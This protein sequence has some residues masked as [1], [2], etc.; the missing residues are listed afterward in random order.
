[1]SDFLITRID[2]NGVGIADTGVRVARCL[3]GE[4]VALT[5][6]NGG[7]AKSRII[8]P[9]TDRVAPPCRHFKRCGG[10]AMQHAADRFVADWKIDIVR[11]GLANQGLETAFRPIITS[12]PQ[13][14]RRATLHGRRTKSGALIGFHARASNTLVEIPDC[15]LLHPDLLAAL[16]ALAALVQLAGSRKHEVAFDVTLSRAGVDVDLRGAK[17]ADMA[18]LAELAKLAERFDLA[19]LSLKGEPVATRRTPYLRFGNARVNFPPGGFLQATA[20]GEAALTAAVV[21]AVAGARR[22][23]DLFAGCGT[24]ALSLASHA[25]VRAIEGDAA[26]CQALDAAWRGCAGLK[27]VRTETRDL[28]RRP[29]WAD[30]FSGVDAVVIDPPRAGAEAQMRQLALAAVAK[31]AMVS[32]NPVSFARDAAILCHAG[33]RLDWVQVVDQFRWSS[34][35]ELVARFSRDPHVN[36]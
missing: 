1:M 15:Q 6:E 34:H 14:R 30:E 31:V 3:P 8:K 35:I 24:F 26:L 4:V 25:E 16:P 32:C 5:T 9:S 18:M 2:S 11:R 12:S 22:V 36:A 23:V 20:E 17:S 10:C 28:F 29:L 13:S 21:D 19:R 7:S 33:F 27:P